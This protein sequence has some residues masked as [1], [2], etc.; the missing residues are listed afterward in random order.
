LLIPAAGVG[1]GVELEP[2]SEQPATS[3]AAS[4]DAITASHERRI[5][6]LD[7]Y[8][9]FAR[10]PPMLGETRGGCRNFTASMDQAG[11]IAR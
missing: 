4:T 6:I 2:L 3:H 5:A 8:N 7:Q 9:A 10:M 11:G 1:S